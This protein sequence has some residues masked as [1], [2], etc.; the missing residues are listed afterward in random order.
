MG[1]SFVLKNKMGNAVGYTTQGLGL[2]RCRYKDVQEGTKVVFRDINGSFIEKNLEASGAEHEWNDENRI[3]IGAAIV[4]EKE[5]LADTGYEMHDY[6]KQMVKTDI[7]KPV[8]SD[9][10][11]SDEEDDDHEGKRATEREAQ[12]RMPQRRWPPPVCMKGA[13]YRTGK[14]KMEE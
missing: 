6:K 1:K 12:E 2:L 9:L 8:S 14:W 13:V 3:M 10:P 7:M 11:D 5:I 4:F